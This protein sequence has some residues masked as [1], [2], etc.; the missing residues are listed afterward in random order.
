MEFFEEEGVEYRMKSGIKQ[1][2]GEN[3]T[4]TS[5]ELNVGEILK[6]DFCIM[7]TGSSLYTEF[8]QGSGVNLNKNGS[9][10]ADQF[11]RSNIQDIYV[12]G[13]VAN[14]PVF[15]IGGKKA[16]IGHYPLA[17]Y[18][19]RIAGLNMAGTE[20]EIEAVPFF[21]TMVFGK[22]FRYSGYGQ[23]H[24]VHIEGDL[25]AMNF[26]AFYLDAGDN[27]IGLA[28]CGRDPIVAQYSEY[29]SQGNSLHKSQLTPDPFAWT[30]FTTCE[31]RL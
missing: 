5:V 30:K 2:V 13:D 22:S 9:I 23:P 16:T 3:G 21:W 12:G 10:D 4:L 1:C 6:A 27:V 15:S 18:H 11:L 7:G 28:S 24:V 19:G 17:Q 20:T 29:V 14:A 8:L 26:V 31:T 25:K